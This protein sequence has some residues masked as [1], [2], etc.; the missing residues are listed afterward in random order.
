MLCRPSNNGFCVL[1]PAKLNLFL[2]IVARRS[3]GFHEIESVMAAINIYDTLTF[4]A[5]PSDE[6]ELRVVDASPNQR[7]ATCVRKPRLVPPIWLFARRCCSRSMRAAAAGLAFRWS[8]AFHRPP[9]WGVAPAIVPRL[10][11]L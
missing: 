7:S 10:S 11:G 1:A 5:I 3:D 8:N 2:R 6:I 9:A 4:E